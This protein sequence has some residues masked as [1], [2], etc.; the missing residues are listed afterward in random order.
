M[1]FRLL[2]ALPLLAGCVGAPPATVGETTSE[3]VGGTT[4]TN[5]TSVVMVLLSTTSSASI[6][7]GEVVSPHVIMTAAHCVDPAVVGTSGTFSVFTGTT[8]NGNNPTLAVKETHYNTKFNVNDLMSGNDIAVVI[9]QNPTTLTPLKMNRTPIASSM[10]GQSV[11]LVGYGITSGTDTAGT[12][13]GTR[14]D[15]TTTLA[16]VLDPLIYFQD[17]QHLTCEGDSG[18]PAFMTIN[19]TEVIAGITSFGDQGCMQAGY[20][21]RIDQYADSFVQPYIDQFDPQPPDMTTGSDGFPPGTV[22]ATCSDSSQCNSNICAHTGSTGFCTATCDPNN[23]SSC[24][25]GTHCGTIDNSP[26]CVRDSRSSGCDFSEGT[27]APAAALLLVG[28][29]LLLIFRRRSA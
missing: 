9:L 5:D 29:L 21:T 17:P 22:G 7:T 4:D 26:Y 25:M 2:A 20:D 3:I 18:G 1:N 23:M 24:P 27:T 14:R 12:T 10:I 28:A 19:G 13:A 16:G 15:T 6:C 8:F 11:R